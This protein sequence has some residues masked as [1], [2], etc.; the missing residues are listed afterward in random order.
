MEL[1][2]VNIRIALNVLLTDSTGT[3]ENEWKTKPHQ[4]QPN[5]QKALDLH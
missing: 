2:L 3:V 5:S 4:L 1:E